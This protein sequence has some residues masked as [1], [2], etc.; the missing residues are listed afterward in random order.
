VTDRIVYGK[1]ERLD[2][3]PWGNAPLVFELISGSY[4]LDALHPRDRRSTKTN[5]SG[6]FA[7]GLWCSGEGVV[8]AEIRCYLPSGETVSFILPAGTTP[9]NISALLANGQPVP[10]ERQPTIV[11][12]IDDRI[13]AHNSDPNAHPKTRQ[14]LSID[15]DG[16]T[17]FT[18]SEAPSLPHLS[19]LFLNGIKATY[20]VHYNIN[21]AQLNWTDPM[22]L[23]STDSLEVLFR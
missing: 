17:S 18:L 9:I 16:V 4:T 3:S 13:A 11:E 14:V 12:L 22:Q 2:G 15:T 8:P 1:L 20:G 7:K 10:P 6:E 21:A 5:T 19:E 23:E